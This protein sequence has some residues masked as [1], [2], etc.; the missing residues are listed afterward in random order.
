MN[1]ILKNLLKKGIVKGKSQ[2]LSNEEIKELERLISKTKEEHLKQG[3]VFQNIIGIDE[4]ID[5]LLEKI[6]TNDEV[7]NT[8]QEILGKNYFL[9]HISAR[10]NEPEDEGLALHQDSHGEMS[11]M[12]L[13]NDQFNG[14]TFFLDL[15]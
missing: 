10:Y 6:V 14:S 9:R 15:N 3:E 13:V 11:L 7:Q 4:R 12:I 2:L 5:E 8:L 1:T